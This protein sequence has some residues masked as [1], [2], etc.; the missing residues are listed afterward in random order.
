M[1]NGEHLH[2]QR[3]LQKTTTNHFFHATQNPFQDNQEQNLQFIMVWYQSRPKMVTNSFGNR[4]F[5]PPMGRL[6]MHSK[7]LGFFSFKF[8]VGGV[9]CEDFFHFSF[10]PN[11]FPFKFLICSFGSRFVPQGCSQQHLVLILYVLPKVPFSP[12]QVGQKGE[13]LHLSIEFSILGSL[14]SFNFFLKWANQIG[15][16]QQK[17][18]SWTSEA[19]PTNQYGTE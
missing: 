13:A 7:C 4:N 19:P 10:V 6:S 5:M 1:N 17:K 14:H 8:W 16:L 9:W 2:K 11:M 18:K 3:S 15:S 12:I